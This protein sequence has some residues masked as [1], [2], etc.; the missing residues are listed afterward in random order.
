MSEDIG[1]ALHFVIGRSY[2]RVVYG[3]GLRY[4]GLFMGRVICA[5]QLAPPGAPPRTTTSSF[6]HRILPE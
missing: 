2:G 6:S 1:G 4:Y 5:P 3:A